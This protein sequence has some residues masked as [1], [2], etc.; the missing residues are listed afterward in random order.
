MFEMTRPS[1]SSAII[2]MTR[3]PIPGAT[4]T[5]LQ[6][7]LTPEECAELHVAFLLDTLDLAC[8]IKN[9]SVFLAFTPKKQ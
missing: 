1:S 5:R 6:V 2:V 8:A 3:V 4:K 9:V 7:S